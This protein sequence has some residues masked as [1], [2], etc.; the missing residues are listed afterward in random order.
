MEWQN[1]PSWKALIRTIESSS[2]IHTG[3]PKIQALHLRA[4]SK[5]FLN[6]NRLGAVTTLLGNSVNV[7]APSRP[8]A[9]G[10]VISTACCAIEATWPFARACPRLCI[11]FSPNSTICFLTQD[12]IHCTFPFYSLVEFPACFPRTLVVALLTLEEILTQEDFDW[13]NLLWR[14][15]LFFSFL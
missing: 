4:M 11:F 9:V 3:P 1:I 2:W 7:C 5:C 15:I 8:A 6:C 13:L 10:L 12:L 14:I